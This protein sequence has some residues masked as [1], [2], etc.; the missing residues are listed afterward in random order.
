M[1]AEANKAIVRRFHEL[2]DKGD[3]S[4]MQ[5][6][7]SDDFVTYQP[8]MPEPLNGEAFKQL[9]QVFLAAFSQSKV[10]IE[11]EICEGNRVASYGTWTAVHSGEFNGIPATGKTIR[12]SE[13]V[14]DTIVDGKIVE[15]RAQPDLMSLLQQLGAIPSPA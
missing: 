14:I 3:L 4:G 5:A 1:S 9:G 10:T 15:H 6:L 8:G 2:F 12:I 11:G 13:L 7:M